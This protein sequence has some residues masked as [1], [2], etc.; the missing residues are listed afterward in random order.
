MEKEEVGDEEV[1]DPEMIV[2]TVTRVIAILMIGRSDGRT[3]APMDLRTIEAAKT[4]G[5]REG[6]AV[7]VVMTEGPA[8]MTEMRSV[9]RRMGMLN[10]Y[11][12]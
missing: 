1:V 5:V 7:D 12:V 6:D 9:L 8:T 4:I 3:T 11:R 2:V 10:Q